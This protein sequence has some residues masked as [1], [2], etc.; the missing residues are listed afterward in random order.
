M[1]PEIRARYSEGVLKDAMR[2]YGIAPDEIKLLDGF[3]SYIYE[4]HRD[5]NDF[6]LR[7]GH[8]RRRTPS[9]IQGE[10][11][12][13]NYLADGGAGVARAILS[14]AGNLVEAIADGRGGQFLATTFVKA[15]GRPPGE[16]GWTPAL[17]EAYGRLLGRIHALSKHYTPSNPTIRRP[18]WN[19]PQNLDT[20][21]W[22][23]EDEVIL[24]EKSRQVLRYLTTLPRDAN[25]YGLI[26]QD[27]HSG[28]F[29]VTEGNQI[30]LFDFDDCVY[31]WFIYDIAMV[32]FY[33]VTNHHDPR[34]LVQSFWP[35]FWTGYCTE[36]TLDPRW[37][38]E[39]PWFM[40]LREIDL[41]AVIVRSFEDIEHIDE[42][43][44]ARYME[45]RK[46]RIEED[47][48]VVEFDFSE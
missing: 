18:D 17:Y 39:I 10:V 44:S 20:L 42:P 19:D 23:P 3:E 5:G 41:Y 7:I 25:S 22:L 34:G 32:I 45:G 8:S 30:T 33:M 40:K 1:E 14:E 2:R 31:G 43:W 12:W 6:I 47:V 13:I 16:V 21:T 46:R 26:H 11:E 48:P 38:C 9:L 24:I 37:L 36:N 4:Y 28:N 29:F 35:R 27:A 15:P